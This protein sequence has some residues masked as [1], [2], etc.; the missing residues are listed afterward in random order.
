MYGNINFACKNYY[1]GH[2]EKPIH[3]HTICSNTLKQSKAL[4]GGQWGGGSA[5][6]AD[7]RSAGSIVSSMA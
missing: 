6:L 2:S 5:S 3:L 7:Y 1:V 4:T